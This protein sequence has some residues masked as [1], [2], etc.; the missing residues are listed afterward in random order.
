MNCTARCCGKLNKFP[1]FPQ[2]ISLRGR[3]FLWNPLARPYT[4]READAEDDQDVLDYEWVRECTQS[5]LVDVTGDSAPMTLFLWLKGRRA[6]IHTLVE[7]IPRGGAQLIDS[8]LDRGAF[9]IQVY[10]QLAL[11]WFGTR[12]RLLFYY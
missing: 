5:V 1:P 10:D 12:S 9:K 11:Q 4:P 7:R 2:V 8:I 3:M 6:L